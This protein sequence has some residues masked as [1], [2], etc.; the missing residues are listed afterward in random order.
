MQPRSPQVPPNRASLSF[1]TR[2]TFKPSCPAL[3]AATYPPGP[4]PLIVTSNCSAN[5]FPSSIKVFKIKRNKNDR[6]LAAATPARCEPAV[7]LDRPDRSLLSNRAYHS[8]HSDL[9]NRRL[10]RWKDV[11]AC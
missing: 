9:T 5:A 8:L 10:F 6:I 3:T 11:S 7:S 4:E 1:S 2:A